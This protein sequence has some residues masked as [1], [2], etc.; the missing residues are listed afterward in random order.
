MF[1]AFCMPLQKQVDPII[2]FYVKVNILWD[3]QIVNNCN[4]K[5]FVQK[6]QQRPW[7]KPEAENGEYQGAFMRK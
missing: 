7:V 2:F 4:D 1:N 3:M 5:A 6:I